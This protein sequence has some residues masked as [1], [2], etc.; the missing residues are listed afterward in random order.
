MADDAV[1]QIRFSFPGD[2]PNPGFSDR[3]SHVRI[4]NVRVHS[5]A[6]LKLQHVFFAVKRPNAGERRVEAVHRGFGA[7]LQ[8]F[9]DGIFLCKR[10][11][12]IGAEIG[13]AGPSRERLFSVFLVSDIMH[14][15]YGAQFVAR[16]VEDRLAAAQSRSTRTSLGRDNTYFYV[17]QSLAIEGSDERDFLLLQ[18]GFAVRMV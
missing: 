8:D 4:I 12:D 16:S 9:S 11:S 17:L 5:R 3:H 2:Q 14:R 6:R 7:T 15:E 1:G 10:Q 13:K 18:Q